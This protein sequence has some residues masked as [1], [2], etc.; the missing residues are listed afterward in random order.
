[1]CMTAHAGSGVSLLVAPKAG[2]AGRQGNTVGAYM[3]A[4]LACSLYVRGKKKSELASR[5]SETL[6]L[7]EQIA[8][9]L[10][11]LGLFLDQVFKGTED[12]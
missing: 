2:A 11:N 6:T 12:F 7:D 3:C 1:M 9:T 4:D 10:S 5:F 8:R